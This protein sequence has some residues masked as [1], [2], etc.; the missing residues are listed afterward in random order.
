MSHRPMFFTVQS[1]AQET[2]LSESTIRRAVKELELTAH[3]R[4]GKYLIRAEDLDAWVE[5]GPTIRRAEI[6]R[7]A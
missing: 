5:D 6:R 4:G 2:H 3:E 7:L 1:A